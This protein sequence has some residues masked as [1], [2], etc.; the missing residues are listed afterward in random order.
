MR[1][2]AIVTILVALSAIPCLAGRSSVLVTEQM[3]QAA[4]RNCERFEWARAYRDRLIEQVEP[5]MQLS[6]EQLWE[7]LPSQGMPRSSMVNT[8]DGC[9]NCGQ[10]HYDAPYN[11]SRWRVDFFE[12]PWQIQCANCG[13]WFPKN[14]F[15][16]YY[17]SA[18][19]EHHK[20][21]LGAGDPALLEAADG[22]PEAWTDDGTGLQVG[23][24][25]WFVAAH[26]AFRIWQQM[27][28]VTEKMAVLYTLTGDEAY[29]HKAAVLLDR[30]ADLYPEMDYYPHYRLGMECST[31]G[32]GLGRVQ[33]KIWETWTAQML[34][35]A[36]DHIRDAL[37]A[38]EELVAF[39]SRM[40]DRYATGDKSSPE[41]IERHIKDHLLR[42]FIIGVRDGRIAGNAGMHQYAMACAAIALDEPGETEA[43]LD[44]LF[45]PDGGGIPTIL[46]ER[47]GREGFSDEAAFGYSRIPALQ[48]Y[49]LAELLRR[50]RGYDRYDLN[51]DF[52]KFR[53]CYTM[54]GKVRLID[55]YTP[56]WGDGDKCMNFGSTGMTIPVEMALQ[57]Y[58][59][60][61]TPEIAREVWF[62]NGKTLEGLF[63]TAPSRTDQPEDVR[64]HLYADDPEAIVAELQRDLAAPGPLESRNAGG[65]GQATL[66]A[67]MREE[68]RALALY[69]GRMAG[70]GHHDRLNYTLVARDVVMVPDM[71]YPLYCNSTWKKRF[72]WTDHIISHNTCMVND[73]QPDESSY[74]GKTTL[75]ADAD[76]LRVVDVDG[77]DVYE[78]VETYSRCMVMVDVDDE[79]SYVI[80]LFRVRG[81]SNHRLIQNGGGPAVTHSGLQLTT[82]PTGTY[83]GPDVEF[84]AEYDGEHT[85]RYEGTGF[86]YLR[87]VERSGPAGAFWVDWQIVEPRREMPEDWEAHLRV[88]NLTEA[89]EVA[90]CTGEPPKFKGNPPQL[91]YMLRTRYGDDLHTQFVS[92]LEPYGSE[93]F[94]DSVRLLEPEDAPDG[95]SAAVEVTLADGRRDVVLVTEAGG[96]MAAGGVEMNGRVGLVRL[97]GGQVV[98]RVLVQGT[99]LAADDTSLTLATDAI[100]GNLVAWDDSDPTRILLTL[101]GDALNDDLVGRYIIFN[102]SERSDASYRIEAVL[103]EH[104]ISI[105]G[106]SLVERFVDPSDYTAGLIYTIAEGDSF[107][108]PLTATDAPGA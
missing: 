107:V 102:N 3:R 39:S 99:E 50:Y 62:A 38:D 85:S 9:P 47:L 32:S 14:D 80:D 42:E 106:A 83:A 77:G 95:F 44:W 49:K 43:A 97:D 31:G 18:L 91:R 46:R 34:S 52:P 69:Y 105:G 60:Y 6:D 16:A 23:E 21:H 53:N 58:E 15:A 25:K 45:T 2:I 72:A 61:R 59:L 78:G 79:H 10:A 19:D 24:K 33:G 73:T 86:S 82:Q 108:I 36:F 101:A 75:F 94:I 65:H 30:A 68:P 7:L 48:F 20:F 5:W 37:L 41:A 90:L 27:L 76:P 54:C 28:D 96:R 57:G 13:E 8:G 98:R 51:R 92:V 70:H 55:S 64:F 88:H 87:D 84:G 4:L 93:P 35:L 103:D 56:N 89:D 40:S 22:A 67:P 66:Q 29:A 81:G 26:Y 71:G 1:I 11:P 17:E 104:T 12:R 74:S 63:E 100:R